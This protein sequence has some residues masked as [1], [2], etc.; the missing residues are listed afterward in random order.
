[1]FFMVI[2]DSNSKL[3]TFFI[4]LVMNSVFLNWSALQSSRNPLASPAPCMK[5]L[6]VLYS[7]N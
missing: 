3:Q 2:R 4:S 1:M 6:K 7:E 5:S